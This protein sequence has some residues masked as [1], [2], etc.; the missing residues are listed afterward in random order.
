MKFNLLTNCRKN[1][2]LIIGVL[3]VAFVVVLN[4]PSIFPPLVVLAAPTTS[5]SAKAKKTAAVANAVPAIAPT[6]APAPALA[7]KS[8]STIENLNVSA[9]NDFVLEPGKVEVFL[10]PGESVTRNV[11]VTNRTKRQVKFKIVTE[12]FIGSDDPNQAVILL[13]DDKSPYSFKDNLIPDTKEFTLDFGQRISIPVKITVP[14]D[15]QPGGFYSSVIVS[16]EP[17]KDE[18]SQNVSETIARNKIISRLGVLFFVRVNGD[19]NENGSVQD[20]RIGGPSQF[21]IQH[22]PTDFEILFHNSGTVHL[23]PYGTI[24]IS[25]TF[26]QHVATLPINAYFSLPNSVRYRTITWDKEF[27]FGRYTAHLKL[28]RGYGNIVDER[29]ISFWVIPW[30]ILAL[31]FGVIFVLITGIYLFTRKFEFK[32]KK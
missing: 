17:D 19:A 2:R 23:V 21:L 15:A 27:L 11:L 6:S 10:N 28:N 16:N 1:S 24:A 20:F 8:L 14:L 13:G 12:D 30:K 18:M 22:G 31:F 7:P 29:D 25:D 26:G 32:R 5:P 3:T 9:Q 4:T